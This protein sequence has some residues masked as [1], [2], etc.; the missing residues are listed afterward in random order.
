MIVVIGIL[1]SI[2]TG[3]AGSAR[4]SAREKRVRTQLEELVLMIESY[5][6]ELGFYPP[7]TQQISGGQ[8]QLAPNGKPMVDPVFTP[9]FYELAG[10]VVD[11]QNGT[12]KCLVH[13]DD[14][15]ITSEVAETYFG[16]EGFSNSGREA[17]DVKFSF[18]GFEPDDIATVSSRGGLEVELLTVPMP[19]PAKLAEDNPNGAGVVN[20]WRYNVSNPTKNPAT[21]DLWAEVVD[22]VDDQG[23]PI[24]RRIGNWTARNADAQ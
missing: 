23:D 13:A 4:R 10:V 12:F 6:A 3:V 20:T 14:E 24:I 2:V 18:V 21:F 17:S 15:A 1:A 9:L 5:K 16:R 11:P 22:G 19:W 7:D 8:V